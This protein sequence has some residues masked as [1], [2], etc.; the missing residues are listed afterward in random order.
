MPPVCESATRL[1]GAQAP[2]FSGLR[3]PSLPPSP[4]RCLPHTSSSVEDPEH[5]AP[6]PPRHSP[7]P[8]PS[9]QKGRGRGIPLRLSHP[10]ACGFAPLTAGAASR[11]HRAP[12]CWLPPSFQYQDQGLPPAQEPELAAS[13]MYIRARLQPRGGAGWKA[14]STAINL[15]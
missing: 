1:F 10:S 3:T 9:P 12:G 15:P 5:E 8:S 7:S 2:A 14:G 4:R 6:V 11:H 13:L